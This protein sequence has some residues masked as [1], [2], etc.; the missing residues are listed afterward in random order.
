MENEHIDIPVIDSQNCYG[1][2]DADL[3]CY[4]PL[5]VECDDGRKVVVA[6]LPDRDGDL[7][8]VSF[9]VSS[10]M[11]A[12]TGK[13]KFKVAIVNAAIQWM[14]SNPEDAVSVWQFLED[15]NSTFVDYAAD[16]LVIAAAI[17]S[18]IASNDYRD[19]VNGQFRSDNGHL[20]NSLRR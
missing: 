19:T 15:F 2:W 7:Q 14:C 6:K 10:A 16:G 5:I 4:T 12:K 11:D 18:E 9:Q 1:Y 3:K 8:T 13:D 17:Q 20:A